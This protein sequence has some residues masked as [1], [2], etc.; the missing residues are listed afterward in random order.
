[1]NI[2]VRKRLTPNDSVGELIQ[3]SNLIQMSTGQKRGGDE[4]SLSFG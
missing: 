4:T 3:S 2:H 1:M